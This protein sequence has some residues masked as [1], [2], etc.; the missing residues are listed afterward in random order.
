MPAMHQQVIRDRRSMLQLAPRITPEDHWLRVRRTAMACSFEITF[1]GE[2]KAEIAAA[3]E[4]LEEA[5]RLENRLTVFR[6]DSVLSDLNRRAGRE[7]VTVDPDIWRLMT[8]CFHVWHETAG[9]FDITTTPLS[10]CWGF[11]DRR[12]GRPDPEALEAARGLIGMDL[13]ALSPADRSVRF[14]RDGVTLN[15]GSIG[16]GFAVKRIA[17]RLRAGGLRHAL[18]SAAHSSIV[19]VGGRDGG[20]PLDICSRRAARR[21]LARVRVRSC[22]VATSGA[23]EQGFEIDGTRYGHLIDPRTGMPARGILSA[24]AIADDGA[25]ADALATAFFVGGIEVARRY[26]DRHPDTLA[27][28]TPDD[29]SERAIAI[30]NH[31]GAVVEDV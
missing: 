8:T 28:L 27:L 9:A 15:F 11:L 25:L 16:K 23:A 22:A 10:R 18:V 12:P 4:S 7:Q 6:D 30:G 17:D 29:G 24:T 21:R 5:G 14:T 3:I 2:Q 20:W 19:A 1:S 13:V 31:R 26:C